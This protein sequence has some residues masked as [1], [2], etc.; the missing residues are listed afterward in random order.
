APQ[1]QTAASTA[2]TR[3][4]TASCRPLC[5]P[6]GPST[7]GSSPCPEGPLPGVNPVEAR[8]CPAHALAPEPT[9]DRENRR[10]VRVGDTPGTS[11][12]SLCHTSTTA[13]APGWGR[14]C[15]APYPWRL[16]IDT[17]VS[18]NWPGG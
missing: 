16:V 7:A 9:C 6:R 1:P 15:C 12:C 13:T 18:L 3:A 5:T 4:T 8:L 2:P 11:L 14:R 17:A 10:G